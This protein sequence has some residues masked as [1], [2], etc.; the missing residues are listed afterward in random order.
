M[1]RVYVSELDVY[2]P[3]S[4]NRKSVNSLQRDLAFM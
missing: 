2:K 3:N 4:V 1:I